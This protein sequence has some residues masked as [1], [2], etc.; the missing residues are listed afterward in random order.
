VRTIPRSRHGQLGARQ[1][2]SDLLARSAAA[3]ATAVR[4]AGHVPA[5]LRTELDHLATAL[6][7]PLTPS[8][9]ALAD[10]VDMER[11]AVQRLSVERRRGV[12]MNIRESI[13]RLRSMSSRAA[14]IEAVPDEVCRS[15]GF[16][17]A[18]LSRIDGT[19]WVPEILW[20]T[21]PDADPV[22]FRSHLNAARIPLEHL[23]LETDMA[24]RVRPALI[25][26][27]RQDDRTHKGIILASGTHSYAAAPIA[28]GRRAVGFL[29]CDRLGQEQPLTTEDRDN[30]WT[31]VEQLTVVLER[32]ALGE[33]LAAIED[34]TRNTADDL[35]TDIATLRVTPVMFGEERPGAIGPATRSNERV[36]FARLLLALTHRERQVLELMATGAA[37]RDIADTFVLSEATIKT[38]VTRILRK[39]RVDN[40]AQAVARYLQSAR[41]P[42]TTR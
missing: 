35:L 22:D 5:V 20:S 23:L 1:V 17:R 38:H 7:E 34:Q 28:P 32:V 19:F 3:R 27:A 2:A 14:I 37:N 30:L 40:R 36:H 12:L 9:A 18:L 24:R 21:E 15:C 11:L 16:A 29:H 13:A 33:R 6:R 25:S 4:D 42:D 8:R 31:F 26:D 41:P 10:L 39:L